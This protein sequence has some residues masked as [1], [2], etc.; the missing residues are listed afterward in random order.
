MV[1]ISVLMSLPLM[2]AVPDVGGNKPVRMDLEGKKVSA[3]S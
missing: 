3:P 1:S 2:Y